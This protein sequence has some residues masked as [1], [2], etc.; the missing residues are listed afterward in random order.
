MAEHIT[1]W[2]NCNFAILI[3]SVLNPLYKSVIIE[4]QVLI[5]KNRTASIDVIKV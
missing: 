4:Y 5:N 1:G 2:E 3:D